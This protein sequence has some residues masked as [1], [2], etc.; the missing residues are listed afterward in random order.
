MATRGGFEWDD[1][2]AASNEAKHGV[3]FADAVEV[4]DDPG[5]VELLDERKPYGERRL[6]AVG[7]VDGVPVT[8]VYT[9]RGSA[10]RIISARRASRAERRMLSERIWRPVTDGDCP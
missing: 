8:V 7:L 2:K 6:L 1:A 3:S 5:R 4:F 9:A 10:R